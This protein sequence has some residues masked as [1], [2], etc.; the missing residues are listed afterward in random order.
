MK[1]FKEDGQINYEDLRDIV[2][3]LRNHRI[4]KRPPNDNIPNHMMVAHERHLALLQQALEMIHFDY[5]RES[6]LWYKLNSEEDRNDKLEEIIKD[7]TEDKDKLESEVK[8]LKEKIQEAQVTAGL[9]IQSVKDK[10]PSW[11]SKER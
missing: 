6:Y 2:W 1:L 7:L 3:T 4:N 9:F 8:T 5:Q 10:L 11:F